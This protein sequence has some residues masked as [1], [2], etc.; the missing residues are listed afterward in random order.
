MNIKIVLFNLALVFIITQFLFSLPIF[1]DTEDVTTFF[2][3]TSSKSESSKTENSSQTSKKV[4]NSSEKNKTSSKITKPTKVTATQ[5]VVT[6]DKI[7]EPKHQTSFNSLIISSTHTPV[8]QNNYFQI[9]LL[10]SKE[11]ALYKN[12][13]NTILASKNIVD[14]SALSASDK[15]VSAA[16]QQVLADYPEFFYISKSY[17]LIYSSNKNTVQYVLILYTDGATTDEFNQDIEL[18]KSADRKI[19]NKKITA[20]NKTVD[21]LIS[22]IPANAADVI[23]E[24]LVHDFIAEKVTY[25]IQSAE[26]IDSYDITIP[27]AFDIYG[28]AVEGAAVCEG[29]SKLFQFLCLQV[30]INSTQVIGT[31]NGGGHMWNAV[32]IDGE[33][34]QLDLTWNDSDDIVSYKYF[35]LT[36]QEISKDH[37]IDSTVL[38]VPNCTSLENSFKNIFAIYIK[39]LKHPPTKYENAVSNTKAVNG[40]SV[41][42][43][44]EGHELDSIGV[45]KLKKYTSF[46]N[47]YFFNPYSDFYLYLSDQELTLSNKIETDYEYIILNFQ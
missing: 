16:F 45:I 28:A 35:N 17:V 1:S 26:N 6:D 25:D 23:K 8:N 27:H 44:I 14:T 7:K 18:T 47:R 3:E 24:R 21:H 39:D 29:Y 22:K 42:I 12:I 2:S 15:D 37:L 32:L 11:K 36:T 43:Y 33:W 41:Y 20:L 40:K 46:L 38:A 34:Y 9:S 19:I 30:G 13:L 31:S 5:T 10:N 4:T